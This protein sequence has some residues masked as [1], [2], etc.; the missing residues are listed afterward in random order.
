MYRNLRGWEIARE[1]V[2]FG[3]CGKGFETDSSAHFRVGWGGTANDK[4]L[5]FGDPRL[6]RCCHDDCLLPRLR[7]PAYIR[8][9]SH[10]GRNS[11][12]NVRTAAKPKSTRGNAYCFFWRTVGLSRSADP[13]VWCCTHATTRLMK[14]GADFHQ[15][16]GSFGC[17]CTV[18]LCWALGTMRAV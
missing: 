7:D 13:A 3:E 10:A 4:S 2:L 1:I 9:Y 6:R 17:G 12:R 16:K 18:R 8:D 11:G 15:K 14:P 5:I